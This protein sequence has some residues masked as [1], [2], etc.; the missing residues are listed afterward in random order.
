MK[1]STVERSSFQASGRLISPVIRL[2]PYS[3]KFSG[4]KLTNEHSWASGTVKGEKFD[5]FS[6]WSS[7]SEHGELVWASDDSGIILCH[8]R[9]V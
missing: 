5:E 4:E 8:A 9:G 7:S 3:L 2:V 1:Q 6:Q